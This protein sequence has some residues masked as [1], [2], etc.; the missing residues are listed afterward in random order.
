MNDNNGIINAIKELL[1]AA[2]FPVLE[3]VYWYLMG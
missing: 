1:P 3:F 2:P